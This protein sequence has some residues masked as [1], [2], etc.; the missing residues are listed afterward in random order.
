MIDE[1]DVFDALRRDGID[2]DLPEVRAAVRVV[3]RH[4][5]EVRGHTDPYAARRCIEAM[6][7]ALHF[8]LTHPEVGDMASFEGE[9]DPPDAG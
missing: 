2:A 9:W 4:V 6:D 8:M 3:M 7:A 1:A 5:E